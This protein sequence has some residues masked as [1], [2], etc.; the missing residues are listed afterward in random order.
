MNLI[1]FFFYFSVA[2]VSVHAAFDKV[3][4]YAHHSPLSLFTVFLLL[5]CRREMFCYAINGP[6][7]PGNFVLSLLHRAI[8]PELTFSVNGSPGCKESRF[9][10]LNR[11]QNEL[12]HFTQNWAFLRF[13]N[14]KGRKYCFPPHPLRTMLCPCSSYL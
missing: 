3:F 11:R 6:F 9:W 4:Q 8:I 1:V 10:S 14:F 7:S 2:P 13:I 5:F 12:R